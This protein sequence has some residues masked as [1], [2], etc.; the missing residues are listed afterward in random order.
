MALD[1][2]IPMVGKDE[3]A[4]Q[5]PTPDIQ[6]ALPPGELEQRKSLWKNLLSQW[7]D[8]NVK[9]AVLAT[10]IGLMRS[11]RYGENVGDVAA[12]ALTSGVNTLQSL[13][14]RDRQRALEAQD[15]AI[16]EDQRAKENTRGDRQVATGE[17]NA[18]TQEKS[19]TG[20]LELGQKAG[21]RSDKALEE[22]IRSNKA[23]EEI[24]R[25]K[26]GAEATRAGAYATGRQGKTAAEIQ[27]I[28]RLKAYYKQ[29]DPSLSDEQADKM[30]IDYVTTS[31]NKTQ[32][33]IAADLYKNELTT[34]AQNFDN[35]GKTPSVADL[36]E[37]KR[38]SMET[39]AEFFKQENS[40][41]KRPDA[42][43]V[44]TMGGPPQ[45]APGA[46]P[47]PPSPLTQ[48]NIE[49]WK[50]A[51]ATPGQ[52]RDLIIKRGEDPKIYGY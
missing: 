2:N 52:I 31:Q 14:E 40:T 1:F 45:A 6:S 41:I 26:A 35:I 19:V 15:R 21:A 24:G 49:I 36:R 46:A 4:A 18:A 39:A 17:R 9:Q 44:P 50:K 10:G 28:D 29:Q 20:N 51:N 37:M 16:R 7:Q 47:M 34:W 48:R 42:P 11:A 33:Q 43:G 12:N 30:A 22:T 13:R 27:K 8:P 3:V 38:R 32:S 23:Q 25:T 5:Q